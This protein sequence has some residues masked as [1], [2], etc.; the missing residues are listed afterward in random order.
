MSDWCGTGDLRR[1]YALVY[2]AGLLNKAGFSL[3]VRLLR[4]ELYD[5]AHL[6]SK[7]GNPE[8]IFPQ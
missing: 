1:E 8:E 6:L 3:G 5:F 7:A 4:D 2:R